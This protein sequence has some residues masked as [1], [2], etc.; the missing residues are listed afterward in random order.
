[1]P[2][3]L[4]NIYNLGVS[5]QDCRCFSSP[6][7]SFCT[8]TFGCACLA[9]THHHAPPVR[10][11][12]SNVWPVTHPGPFGGQQWFLRWSENFLTENTSV[13]NSWRITVWMTSQNSL[14]SIQTWK[15]RYL[16]FF[17]RTKTYLSFKGCFKTVIASCSLC[18]ASMSSKP[19]FHFSIN[20]LHA[21]IHPFSWRCHK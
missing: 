9:E 17:P 14:H 1:M 19:Y 4:F 8:C 15:R 18:L 11:L 5:C 16:L 7:L 13:M 20:Q 10:A 6:S 2:N 21:D 3:L 12:G